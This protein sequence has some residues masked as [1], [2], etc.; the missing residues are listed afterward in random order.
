MSRDLR[1]TSTWKDI[2]AAM[3]VRQAIVL[4]SCS[5]P[6]LTFPNSFQC[7]G[8]ARDSMLYERTIQFQPLS[9]TFIPTC[10]AF[11]MA[12]F[13]CCPVDDGLLEGNSHP[14]H[15]SHSRRPDQSPGSLQ[16]YGGG[17]K[18][19]QGL[20]VMRM[21]FHVVRTFWFVEVTVEDVLQTTLQQRHPVLPS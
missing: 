21:D 4:L 15:T 17:F 1:D 20:N 2:S 8:R 6:P 11:G 19:V 14:L 10:R 13:L 5:L 7:D 12:S 3:Q 18:A 16:K 9:L